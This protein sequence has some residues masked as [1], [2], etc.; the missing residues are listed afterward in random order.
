M[1]MTHAKAWILLL[2]GAFVLGACGSGESSEASE[3]QEI[4]ITGNDQMQFS[5]TE[6]TVTAGEEVKV[7]LRNVG[8][9]PKEAMGHNLVILKMGNEVIAFASASQQYPQNGY[10]DPDLEGQ[11]LESTRI[12]GPGEE[13]TLTFTAPSEKGDY[14]FLCSFPAH[15][16][17]GMQGVMTVE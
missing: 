11:V 5:L 12:L 13:E 2:A 4:V 16:M 10:I 9:M 1:N 7:T 8:E 6:F 14:P 3:P 15:A 17:S